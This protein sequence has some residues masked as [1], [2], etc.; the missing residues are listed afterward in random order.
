MVDLKTFE[1]SLNYFRDRYVTDGAT[2]DRFN[3]LNFRRN[4]NRELVETV[5]LGDNDDPTETV[6]A[7]LTIVFR[8]RNNLF[9]GLKWAYQMRDQQ[10][11]FEQGT[12]V[13]T[14]VLDCCRR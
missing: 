13:M 6:K 9:H 1:P 7:L 5:L 4:D 10:A 3:G 11:N 8:L 14:G 12:V 2:N